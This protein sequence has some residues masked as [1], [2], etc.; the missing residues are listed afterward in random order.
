MDD[1]A[2]ARVS[3]LSFWSGPVSPVSLPGGLSNTNFV[4]VDRDQRFV[5]RIGADVPEHAVWRFNEVT[6]SRAAYAAGLSPG[7]RHHEAD[8]MV[9]DYIENGQ[10]L[11]DRQIRTP[12]MLPRVVE[13][14]RRC[15]DDLPLHLDVPGPMFWVFNVNRRYARLIEKDDGRLASRLPVFMDHNSAFEQAVGPIQ[16]VFCH[17][18]LLAANLIDDGDR[19]WL[20]DWEY[21]G[22]NS[23]LFDLANLASNN[24]FDA[25]AEEKLLRLYFNHQP[26]AELR[27]RFAAMKSASLLREALWSM[28]AELHSALDIDFVAYTDEN[29]A[30]FEAALADFQT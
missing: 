2:K 1:R 25:E 19:L 21:G 27:Y 10:P 29:L 23:A 28:V 8:A 7:V 11:E 20:I 12:D 22:W 9:I 30:R 6:V 24:S 15:H 3:E 14:V 26:D 5:V 4:V 16:P 17:N 13:L 18:D